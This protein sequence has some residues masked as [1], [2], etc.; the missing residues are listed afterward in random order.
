MACRSSELIFTFLYVGSSSIQNA[1]EQ[2]VW[3]IHVYR[4][5]SFITEPHKQKFN[6]ITSPNSNSSFAVIILYFTYK[7]KGHPITS[8]CGLQGE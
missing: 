6:V 4:L 3:S 7:G 1:N 8:L 2:R 5:I